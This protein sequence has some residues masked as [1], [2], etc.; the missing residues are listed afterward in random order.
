MARVMIKCPKTGAAVETGRETDRE[1]WESP[2]FTLS[3]QRLQECPSCGEEHT[4]SQTEAF[5][6]D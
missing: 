5:L 4:W 1:M 6:E 2:A 3:S